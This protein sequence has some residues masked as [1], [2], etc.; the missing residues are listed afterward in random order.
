MKHARIWSESAE[1]QQA[2]C[3]GPAPSPVEE[4]IPRA[5]A[6]V[7]DWYAAWAT[8]FTLLRDEYIAYA[9]NCAPPVGFG[10]MFQSGWKP[11]SGAT[12]C[13]YRDMSSAR[14]WVDVHPRGWIV[15]LNHPDSELNH[16]DS[17]DPDA[18]IL[19]LVRGDMPVLCPTLPSA[20]R[21]AEFSFPSPHYFV[22]WHP[23]W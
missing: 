10:Y 3:R 4:I 2:F 11:S 20:V 22:Y 7:P 5:D 23:Y 16:P 12:N 19:T 18:R 1:L 17:P 15:E 9:T 6:D 8:D 21:L 13:Y 14:L